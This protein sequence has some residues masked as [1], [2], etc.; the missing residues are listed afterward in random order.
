MKSSKKHGNWNGIPVTS[1]SER[2]CCEDD[3]FKADAT[4]SRTSHPDGLRHH[5]L[6]ILCPYPGQT[7]SSGHPSF[8][9]SAKHDE[10]RWMIPGRGKGM[11]SGPPH[12]LHHLK[13]ELHGVLLRPIRLHTSCRFGG[14]LL[15][16]RR[17]DG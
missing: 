12:A 15:I 14:K 13:K 1:D 9:I 11:D 6:C 17:E 3:A 10:F 7:Y 4:D 8:A 5:Y 2:T 16:F